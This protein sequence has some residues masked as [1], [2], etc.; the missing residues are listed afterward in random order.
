MLTTKTLGVKNF[1][2]IFHINDT[3]L[4]VINSMSRAKLFIPY[5]QPTIIVSI[6]QINMT[7]IDAAYQSSN[8]K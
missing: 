2:Q 5:V 7:D 3:F 4:P 8:C 6:K 1:Q